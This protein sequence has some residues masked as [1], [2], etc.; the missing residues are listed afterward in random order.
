MQVLSAGITGNVLLYCRSVHVLH[1]LYMYMYACMCMC[2]WVCVCS[3]VFRVCVCMC[4]CVHLH[5]ENYYW[6]PYMH[7]GIR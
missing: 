1:V 5:I 6:H 7:V 3:C 2:A 4:L